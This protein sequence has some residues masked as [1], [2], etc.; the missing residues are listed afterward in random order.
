MIW[1]EPPISLINIHLIL[2]FLLHGKLKKRVA[3]ALVLF[4]FVPVILLAVIFQNK[5]LVLDFLF[6]SVCFLLCFIIPLF[7]IKNVSKKSI[8]YISLLYIGLS[9]SLVS[10]LRW[11]ASAVRADSASHIIINVFANLLLLTLVLLMCKSHKNKNI[12]LYEFTSKG[13]KGV[14]LFSVYLS[15]FSANFTSVMFTQFPREPYVITIEILTAL[16]IILLGVM[17][18]VLIVNSS[19]R[20][21]YQSLSANME[22]QICAQ[23]KHYEL[24]T[25][26]NKDVQKFKHD[27]ENLKIGLKKHLAD[28]DTEGALNYLDECHSADSDAVCFET[29]NRVADALLS[30]KSKTAKLFNTCITFSGVLPPALSS[31]DVCVI[32]GNAL[33]NAIEACS[34]IAAEESKTIEITS[35]IESRILYIYIRNP[36][37][38]KVKISDNHIETT[39]HNKKQ[40]GI[41]L[42]SIRRAAAKYDGSVILSADS[43]IFTIKIVL[44]FNIMP[45]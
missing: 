40:H 42:S 43:H 24:L 20:T 44:D 34:K 11:I 6:W 23:V 1:F 38:G 19:F 21:Y 3:F 10:S 16:L 30:E 35:N 32:L 29:G 37:A 7:S 27:F 12:P 45:Y 31:A 39:K 5:N 14:L 36:V 13:I 18:P 28:K 15:V 17:C 33:D 22:K 9:M 25:E 8:F 2:V 26:M 4:L 41:G